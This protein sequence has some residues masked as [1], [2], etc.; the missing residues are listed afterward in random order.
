VEI[1]LKFAKLYEGVD[2]QDEKFLSQYFDYH[3]YLNFMNYNDKTPILK[4]TILSIAD[5][6][7]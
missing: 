7:N 2:F 3:L 5:G 6:Y 4:E 1:I